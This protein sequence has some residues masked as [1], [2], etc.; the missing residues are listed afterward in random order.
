MRQTSRKCASSQKCAT[1]GKMSNTL[2]NVPDL[3]KCGTG[4]KIKQL[5]KKCATLRKMCRTWNNAS[6]L[7]NYATL[8]KMRHT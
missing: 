7:E 1:L 3:T 8:K 6:Q 2:K 4:G 5:W